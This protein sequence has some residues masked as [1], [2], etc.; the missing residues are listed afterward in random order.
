MKKEFITKFESFF[1]G[2]MFTVVLV[3]MDLAIQDE[4][5]FRNHYVMEDG[6]VEWLTVI[7][8]LWGFFISIARIIK[9]RSQR[10]VLFLVCLAGCALFFLFGA[11]EEISW[12]Q[13]IFDIETPE[14]LNEINTQREM[15]LHNIRIGKV[16]INKLIFGLIL[17]IS[18][19]I[20]ISLLP[21]LY[22]K[23]PQIKKLANTCA[24]PIPRNVH[25]LCFVL[26]FCLN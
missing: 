21:I 25:I 5:V 26:L 4:N 10:S 20:Y 7:P 11:G 2:A 3:G 22:Y 6:L 14:S 23:L 16:K 12:G 15:N 17:G 1:L 18:I 19:G 8:L 9:L 24:I 13:R